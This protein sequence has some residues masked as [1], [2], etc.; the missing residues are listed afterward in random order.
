LYLYAKQSPNKQPDHSYRKEASFTKK[1][2]PI[3][4]SAGLLAKAQAKAFVSCVCAAHQPQSN[5]R[6]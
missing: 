4:S 5:K 2:S 6:P 1:H 3:V